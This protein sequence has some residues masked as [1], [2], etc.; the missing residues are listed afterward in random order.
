MQKLFKIED[1]I[2]KIEKNTIIFFIAIMVFFSFLQVL[3]RIIFHSG[4]VWLDP[5]L[6]HCVLWAGFLGAALASRYSKHFALD[7]CSKF[8]PM[9]FRKPLGI[10]IALCTSAA[11]L[12]LFIAAWK[13]ISDEIASGAIAFYI[14][15]IPI[16][17]CYA[18]IIIPITFALVFFH[19]TLG[20]F[21]PKDDE[22]ILEQNTSKEAVK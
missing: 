3:L 1:F 8:A 7:L 15:H 16:K 12:M 18:E 5:L 10:F 6:R 13:F 2:I 11:A 9:K 22:E 14:N 17:G 19:C 4:I 21:R 20:I